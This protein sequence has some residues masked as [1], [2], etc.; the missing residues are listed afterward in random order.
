MP[1]TVERV[2]FAVEVYEDGQP[3]GWLGERYQ[4]VPYSRSVTWSTREIAQDN[5]DLW[6]S[7]CTEDL[8][9]V[10]HQVEADDEEEDES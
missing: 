2:A 3:I 8:G 6:A 5:I 10:I 4:V 9:A 1:A 7:I